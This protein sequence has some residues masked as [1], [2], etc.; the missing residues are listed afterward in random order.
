MQCKKCGA[1]YEGNFCPQCGTPAEEQMRAC[2]VC[3]KERGEDERFCKGCGYDFGR[4]TPAKPAEAETSAVAAAVQPQ[5][6]AEETARA[7]EPAAETAR[8]QEPVVVASV[9]PQKT[10]AAAVRRPFPKKKVVTG[11][12][13]V[14]VIAVFL[15][16]L[17]PTVAYFSNKFRIDVVEKISLGASRQ[18]VL[19]VLGEPYDY[20]E[21]SSVFEYYS[22]NYRK[23]L[24]KND[25]FDP[26]DI[27]DWEDF[28]D[29]FD[30]ALELE[31]KLQ[32]EEYQYI[33]VTFDSDGGV[34][35][36]FFD[37]NRCEQNST[38]KVLESYSLLRNNIGVSFDG[39]DYTVNE[40]HY[41][42]EY[43]D[44][45]YYKGITTG[46]VEELGNTR[47]YWSDRFGNECSYLASA[48]MNLYYDSLE[49][50]LYIYSNSVSQ[51]DIPDDVV[52]VEFG[53]DVSSIGAN[54][55]QNCSSLQNV[56]MG[57][58]ITFIGTGAFAGC[59]GLN[60]YITDLSKWCQ[61]Q[62]SQS[63]SSA[64]YGDSNPIY[65]GSLYLNG[66]LL[67]DIVIPDGV[68]RVYS[69]AFYGYY[70]M[71]SLYIP[72][73]V[74]N[75]G[76]YC[77]Y[78]CGNLKD[79]VIENG[80]TDIGREAF[81]GCASLTSVMIPDSVTS[82]GDLAFYGC[83]SLTSVYI[84]D[85]AAWCAIDFEFEGANP[86]SHAHNLYLNGEL[87]TDLVIPDSVTSIGEYAFS[88]CNSLTSVTIPDSV[89]SIGM[90]AFYGC[91]SLTSVTIPDSV[92][93]IGHSAFSGCD[94]LT[95]ITIPDSVTF[96]GG[97]AFSGCNS[98][99][100]VIFENP[101]GWSADR[102]ALSAAD[103]SDPATAAKYLRDTYIYALTRE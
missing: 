93:S 16:I 36:V 1:Q 39:E 84:T 34:S 45:S 97:D 46:Y 2:P 54:L 90:G 79:V 70:Q 65:G 32:T 41:V 57:D 24:E 11:I 17:I 82:I 12:A 14:A 31:Q 53:E 68:A 22:D 103:L 96:I 44:G 58:N 98:L 100:S 75:I 30:E 9:Q 25:S 55:F 18:S 91:N 88:G 26:D 76:R 4:E 66:E 83:D 6:P 62:F 92:T 21:N 60:V 52:T 69:Y 95:S 40:L 51:E 94:S 74:K 64:T 7:Q 78:N 63:S 19:N 28:G 5:E 48:G 99:T 86:L 20:A 8:P 49:K 89:T 61:I 77:F 29:A 13:V 80:V 56:I 87:V 33:S 67:T 59:S 3:G 50:V 102:E 23:L 85:M 27:Q 101:N 42:A 47:V 10:V 15:A 73:S 37:A 71:E 43:T 81:Y 38:K 72:G 35:S